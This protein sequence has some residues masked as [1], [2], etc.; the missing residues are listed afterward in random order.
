[1]DAAQIAPDETFVA[2]GATGAADAY[3]GAADEWAAR[4]AEAAPD[5]EG[6]AARRLYDLALTFQERS[7]TSE[8][9]LIEQF[10][11]AAA[12]LTGRLGD[13]IVVDDD[14]ERL[15]LRSGGT[16]AAEVVPEEDEGTWR[17]L[18]TPAELV[19]FYDPTDVFGDVAEALAEAFPDATRD[20]EALAGTDLDSEELEDVTVD[21]G[22]DDLEPDGGR[23]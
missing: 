9:R 5:D 12:P 19:E 7:Q 4:G 13:L 1:M 6:S 8:A 22:A 2:T 10:E 11:S 14:D 17:T 18:E 21:E 20:A 16:F 15:T 3:A 23:R